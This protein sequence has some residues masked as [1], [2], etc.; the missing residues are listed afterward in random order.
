MVLQMPKSKHDGEF[1][2][3]FNLN[4]VKLEEL[5]F[6]QDIILLEHVSVSSTKAFYRDI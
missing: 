2:H 5:C 6:V 1:D 3:I 4:L